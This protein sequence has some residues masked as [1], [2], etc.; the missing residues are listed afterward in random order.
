ML[1]RELAEPLALSFEGDGTRPIT[2]AAP[3]EAAGQSGLAFVNSLKLLDASDQ[4]GAGCLVVPV[5]YQNRA[6]RTILR[7]QQPRAAFAEA[8]AR[9]YP[10]RPVVPGISQ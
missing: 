4:S 2:G 5:A 3:L 1:V 6:D 7:A 8:L 10:A 9:L